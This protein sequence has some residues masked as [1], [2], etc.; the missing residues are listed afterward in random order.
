[1]RRRDLAAVVGLVAG[2]APAVRA[3]PALLALL[4][5][6]GHVV[7]M[8]HAQTEPGVG[9]PEGMVLADC[10]TQR[11]LSEAGRAQAAAAGAALRAQQVPVERLISSPWC[12]C[13]ETARLA[14]GRAPAISPALGNLFGRSD[15]QGRQVAQMKAL[16]ERPAGGNRVLVS[17]GSTIQALTGVYL[18]PAEMLVVTPQGDGRFAVAGRLPAPAR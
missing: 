15:P 6:G 4:Q 10:A 12:R 14:F 7:L 8:R 2:L 13:V 18:A 9:D 11:N 3:D 17:H 5:R 16:V 1:M